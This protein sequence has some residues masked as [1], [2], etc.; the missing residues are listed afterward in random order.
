MIAATS[1]NIEDAWESVQGLQE[2]DHFF[3]HQSSI[4][5]ACSYPALAMASSAVRS[6]THLLMYSPRG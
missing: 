1:K 4:K 3:K 2:I 5:A 6:V